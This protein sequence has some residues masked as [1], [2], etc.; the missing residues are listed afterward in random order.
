MVWQVVVPVKRCVR[1]VGGG[2][3]RLVHPEAAELAKSIAFGSGEGILRVPAV[4]QFPAAGEPVSV[5]V[6]SRVERFRFRFGD[7]RFGLRLRIHDGR[8]LQASCERTADQ[9]Q[10]QKEASAC[11]HGCADEVGL[12]EN[13]G[14]Q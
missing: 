9:Q 4:G 12:T 13:A 14:G 5:V 11:A 7:P 6:E 10:Y 3:H 8:G 1:V 2:P